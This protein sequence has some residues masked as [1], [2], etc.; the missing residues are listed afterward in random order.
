MDMGKSK[1]ADARVCEALRWRVD[2]RRGRLNMQ[3]QC[4]GPRHDSALSLLPLV[5]RPRQS[6]D[7]RGGFE[8]LA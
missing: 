7:S 2:I 8:M 6:L 1:Y 4:R 5:M 3:S